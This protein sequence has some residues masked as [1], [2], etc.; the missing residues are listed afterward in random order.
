MGYI[1]KDGV[2]EIRLEVTMGP[3]PKVEPPSKMEYGEFN[4]AQSIA[5]TAQNNERRNIV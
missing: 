2:K 3:E 4:P 1:D 5:T